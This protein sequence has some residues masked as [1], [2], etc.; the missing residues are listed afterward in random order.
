MP[1]LKQSRW[2]RF[3]AGLLLALAGAAGVFTLA[4]AL[5]AFG[6]IDGN[7]ADWSDATCFTDPGGVD[8]ERSPH[9]ADITEFCVHSDASYLY[10][11]MAWDDTGFSGGTAS[12]AG[13]RFDLN[14]DGVYDRFILATLDTEPIS[15]LA[16]SIGSCDGTGACNNANDI[17]SSDGS[18]GGAC[19]GAAGAAN[20]NWDDPYD[21]TPG[22]GAGGICSGTNCRTQD[23][24]VELAVPWN[25]FNMPGLGTPFIFGNFGSYPSGPAQGAKD[26]TGANGIACQPDGTCFVSTP[27]AITLA[28]FSASPAAG[29]AENPRLVIGL[30]GLGLVL[31]A[32]SGAALSRRGRLR[33]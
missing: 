1:S 27:T 33:R 11:L 18:G 26:D 25:L 23:A 5:P 29:F 7:P 21:P 12:T 22:H 2:R 20:G 28:S 13:V 3:L 16:Y 19:T 32:L 30:V 31:A 15:G 24:F 8:D 14:G 9:R 17:C 10:L 4:W 6:T